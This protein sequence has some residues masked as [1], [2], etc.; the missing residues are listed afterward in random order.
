M[1]EPSPSSYLICGADILTPTGWQE[2]D[3]SVVDGLVSDGSDGRGAVLD[4]SGLRIVPGFI[5]L[6]VNGR[7][8]GGC[9]V[10]VI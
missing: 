9:D 2:F 10:E 5:E 3:L 4:A 8:L 1:A 7:V 6:Q